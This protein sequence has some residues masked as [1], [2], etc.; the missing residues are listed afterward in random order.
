MLFVPYFCDQSWLQPLKSVSLGVDRIEKVDVSCGPFT[1]TFSAW[2]E[3][4]C[5]A[6][7]VPSCLRTWEILLAD[8][9]PV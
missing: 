1:P 4:Q 9:D 2:S 8:L 6:P 7:T 3:Q 5:S